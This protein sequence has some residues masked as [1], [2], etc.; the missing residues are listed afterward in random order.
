MRFLMTKLRRAVERMAAD[1]QFNAQYE[2]IMS[3]PTHFILGAAGQRIMVEL[4]KVPPTS[5][6]FF[7]QYIQSNQ[8]R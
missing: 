6:A 5:V 7:N 8:S 1:P 2:K 3:A 4:K